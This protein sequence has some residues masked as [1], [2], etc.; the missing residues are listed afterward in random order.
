[1]YT[2][3]LHNSYLH[4]NNLKFLNNVEY[5]I[6][7]TGMIVWMDCIPH[8]ASTKQVRKCT[9]LKNLPN[10]KIEGKIGK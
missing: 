7:M 8:A 2:L 4:P 9:T 5:Y 6:R 10:M 3:I 1:M